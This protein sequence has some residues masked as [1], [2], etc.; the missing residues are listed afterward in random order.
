MVH[1]FF[2]HHSRQSRAAARHFRVGEARVLGGVDRGEPGIEVKRV[3]HRERKCS[4]GG[5]MRAR[6]SRNGDSAMGTH[7]FF[8][9]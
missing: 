9:D 3:G 5:S 8:A 6:L 4:A 1:A 7:I 2:L